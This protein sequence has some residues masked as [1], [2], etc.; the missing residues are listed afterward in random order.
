MLSLIKDTGISSFA[1]MDCIT[2]L[3]CDEILRL[4]MVLKVRV[5][6]GETQRFLRAQRIG[7]KPTALLVT[8]QGLCLC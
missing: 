4:N 5:R 2:K 1:S 7:W 8:R 6:E 3:G